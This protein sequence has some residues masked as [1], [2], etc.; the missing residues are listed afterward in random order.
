MDQKEIISYINTSIVDDKSK[1]IFSSRVMYSMTGDYTYVE[2]MIK[3][4]EEFDAICSMIR[5]IFSLYQADKILIFGAGTVGGRLYNLIKDSFIIEGFVDN[6]KKDEYMGK[7]VYSVDSVKGREDCI[8][9]ISMWYDSES[10]EEQLNSYGVLAEK[11][12]CWE[13]IMKN[14]FF[15]K[16]YFD[17]FSHQRGER[18]VFIDCGCFDCFNMER[19]RK[20]CDDEYDKIV[21]FEPSE[22]NHSYC[23]EYAKKN[24]FRG[25]TIL[26][27]AVGSKSGK[28]KFSETNNMTAKIDE[29]GNSLVSI[30]KIDDVLNGERA[31][32][33]KMDIEGGEL[34][35]LKGAEKTIKICRPKLAI[36]IYHKKED[37]FEIPLYLLSLHEDYK[38]IF[39]HYTFQNSDT[40]MYMV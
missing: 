24:G 36:S 37:I 6:K 1:E 32:F 10:V 33:I 5:N 18:E 9:I 35:A 19:F 34:E 12:L 27:S 13:K 3:K 2:Q 22:Q 23:K 20:W 26:N 40:V 30:L 15:R 4:S 7:R 38:I 25:T 8:F 11:I 17:V 28:V 29:N 21:A 39:R 16:Q 14:V 31:T